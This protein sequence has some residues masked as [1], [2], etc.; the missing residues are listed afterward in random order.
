MPGWMRVLLIVVGV[1]VLVIV[2][3]GIVG[4]RALKA[5]VP[6]LNAA[7]QK[8]HREGEAYGTGKAPADCID[9]ALRRADRSFTGQVRTR[10]FADACLKASTPPPGWC[11][12]VPSGVVAT[13]KWAAT[14]CNK[15]NLAGDQAC[16]GVYQVVGVYCHRSH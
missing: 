14:E 15:R 12:Q 6:E 1:F 13:A 7:V 16:T 2:V 8:A 9:E 11:D 3:L 10:M 4:Y 5:R